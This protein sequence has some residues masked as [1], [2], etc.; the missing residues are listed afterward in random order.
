MS[1]KEKIKDSK[2]TFA[3]FPCFRVRAEPVCE[4]IVHHGAGDGRETRVLGAYHPLKYGVTKFVY[5]VQIAIF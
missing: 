2:E 5:W 3:C 4:R 1:R